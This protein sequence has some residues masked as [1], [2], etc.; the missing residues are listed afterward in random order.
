MKNKKNWT[1]IIEENLAWL[2]ARPYP[3]IPHLRGSIT[4]GR[5]SHIQAQDGI[6]NTLLLAKPLIEA[7]PSKMCSFWLGRKKVLIITNPVD[8]YNIK[9][10]HKN[11]ISDEVESLDSLHEN[12]SILTEAGSI[13]REKRN[14]YK[15]FLSI[16]RIQSS[17]LKI[18]NNYLNYLKT[19]N[20]INIKDFFDNFSIKLNQNI[21]LGLSISSPDKTSELSHYKEKLVESMLMAT[22]LFGIEEPDKKNISDLKE[23]FLEILE[24]YP[25]LLNQT[26]SSLINAL[27]K[28]NA[29][30]H[31]DVRPEDILSDFNLLILAGTETNS[32][33]LQATIY[34]LSINPEIEKKLL[35]ELRGG[36]PLS[37]LTINQFKYLDKVIKEVF[38]LYPPAPFI[39]PRE[40]KETLALTNDI[41]LE[42]GD[43]FCIFSFLTHRLPEIWKSPEDFNPDRFLEN[44]P[45]N[46][47]YIPFG[48]GDRVC[49]GERFA[50]SIIKFF[51]ACI[52]NSYQ[53]KLISLPS[54]LSMHQS[55]AFFF[56]SPPVV[57]FIP[58]EKSD[59]SLIENKPLN[60]FKK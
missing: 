41:T 7:H 8:I 25:D 46:G 35:Q 43:I 28:I 51:I 5:L 45:T 33:A 32:F 55:S 19:N 31:R 22:C 58:Y 11:F 44:K 20:N 36:H 18:I 21:L 17:L 57:K 56:K 9:V 52:Y 23:S 27:G 48:L 34:L 30:P 14:A 42:K 4:S 37:I 1:Q 10:R 3:N 40:L 49:P 13:W 24:M 38:R 15:H 54:G 59:D 12:Q 16:N 47:A 26:S 6:L 2:M 60:I 53:V 29:K 50:I 39:L